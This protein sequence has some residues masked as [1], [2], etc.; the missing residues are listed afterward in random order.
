[1]STLHTPVDNPH[2]GLQW[3][4]RFRAGRRGEFIG[5]Y[6]GIEKQQRCQCPQN[7]SFVVGSRQLAASVGEVRKDVGIVGMIWLYLALFSLDDGKLAG[8]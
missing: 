1:M 8:T 6:S 3:L 2:L 7:G 5:A 4:L